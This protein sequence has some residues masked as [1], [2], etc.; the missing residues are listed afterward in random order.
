MRPKTTNPCFAQQPRDELPKYE[1][2]AIC[3]TIL[4]IILGFRIFPIKTGAVNDQKVI[5]IFTYIWLIYGTSARSTR[6]P[7]RPWLT[8]R[9][10]RYLTMYIDNVIVTHYTAIRVSPVRFGSVCGAVSVRLWLI[11]SQPKR[12]D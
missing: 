8:Y 6:V 7:D 4:Y 3:Q 2:S 12:T 1:C 5:R 10:S 11:F 9:F